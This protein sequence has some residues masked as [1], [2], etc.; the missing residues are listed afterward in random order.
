MSF[1]RLNE[2]HNKLS[3][4]IKQ[5]ESTLNVPPPPEV[6]NEI[7]YSYRALMEIRELEISQGCVEQIALGYRK[8]IHALFCAYHDLIDG[9]AIDLASIL[10]KFN[11]DYFEE[12]II[13]CSDKRHEIMQLLN[14]VTDIMATSRS[15][16]TSRE[17][18]YDDKLYSNYFDKVLE[19]RK[20]LVEQVTEDIVRLNI[21]NKRK[22]FINYTM[23]G[24]GVFVSLVSVYIGV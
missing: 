10:E 23:A 21:K 7:R 22:K 1:T 16:N 2:L 12:F 14:E 11:D 3:L 9:L 5:Y 24:V 20:Y 15:E 8:A 18:V 13:I 4:R 6:L 17:I 19:Y